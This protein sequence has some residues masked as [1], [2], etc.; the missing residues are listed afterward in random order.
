MKKPFYKKP[1][2][3]LPIIISI[4]VAIV[5]AIIFSGGDEV[6]IRDSEKVTVVYK[7]PGT[8]ITINEADDKFDA[9]FYTKETTIKQAKDYWME[10]A[11]DI[12]NE[13]ITQPRKQIR[14]DLFNVK[15]ILPSKQELFLPEFLFDKSYSIAY[16]NDE[17]SDFYI[18]HK[19]RIFDDFN[20]KDVCFI[21]N[22]NEEGRVLIEYGPKYKSDNE[23][24][25]NNYV[26]EGINCEIK[27]EIE[28]RN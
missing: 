27:T 18:M 11:I 9:N 15:I 25:Y 16:S 28:I 21:H 24:C 19:Y 23:L 10:I 3:I 6:N 5:I 1:E 14:F 7:S 4:I 20:E 8:T 2:W 17:H 12:N 13:T 26:C 22:I